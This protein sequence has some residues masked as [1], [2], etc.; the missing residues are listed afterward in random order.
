MSSKILPLGFMSRISSKRQKTTLT[1]I[2]SLEDQILAL[3]KQIDD[4]E[5]EDEGEDDTESEGSDEP[6]L[7]SSSILDGKTPFLIILT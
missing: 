5:D 1:P 2:I 3:E 7:V 6:V 4:D